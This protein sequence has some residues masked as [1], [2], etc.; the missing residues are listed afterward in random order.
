MAGAAASAVDPIAAATA[1]ARTAPANPSLPDPAQPR[2]H[3]GWWFRSSFSL[4]ASTISASFSVA[5]FS[6][7]S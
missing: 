4:S 7:A 3:L 5:S 2:T 6:T 1:G